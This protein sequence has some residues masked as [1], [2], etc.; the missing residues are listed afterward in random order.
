[1]PTVPFPTQ[2]SANSNGQSP[3][4]SPSPELLLMAAAQMDRM[5]RLSAPEMGGGGGGSAGGLKRVAPDYSR[6]GDLGDLSKEM[7]D[8][9]KS[10][11]KTSKQRDPEILDPPSANIQKAIDTVKYWMGQRTSEPQLA[12]EENIKIMERGGPMAEGMAK[13]MLEMFQ[14][15]PKT[16]LAVSGKTLE[17]VATRM[18]PGGK[19]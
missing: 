1:M 6:T 5:G 16:G 17:G 12:L 2:P 10:P 3:P 19:R 15:P 7:N 4:G 14:K 13:H 11:P 8:L 9:L 18:L